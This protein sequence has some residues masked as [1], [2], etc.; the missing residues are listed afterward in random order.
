MYPTAAFALFPLTKA[1]FSPG[2]TS[3][4]GTG[5]LCYHGRSSSRA[6]PLRVVSWGFCSANL[7]REQR[8]GLG[9]VRCCS[10]LQQQGF[11]W[12]FCFVSRCHTGMA[13]YQGG[14]TAT[15]ARTWAWVAANTSSW[16]EARRLHPSPSCYHQPARLAVPE[17]TKP[18]PPKKASEHVRS[19]S[20]PPARQHNVPN[21]AAAIISPTGVLAC[22]SL[23]SLP[24]G[25]GLSLS[26]PG[27]GA[28]ANDTPQIHTL[29]TRGFWIWGGLGELPAPLAKA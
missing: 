10:L 13:S 21:D 25:L 22:P 19:G 29:G 24:D 1:D 5:C 28:E 3:F 26:T 20:V 16:L 7:L 9:S 18:T 4:L 15:V 6:G 12:P 11:P 23:A 2:Y 17:Q 8:R 27:V 14:G